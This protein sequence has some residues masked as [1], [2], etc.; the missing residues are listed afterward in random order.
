MKKGLLTV[1]FIFV[2]FSGLFSLNSENVTDYKSIEICRDST[3][4]KTI[5]KL[6]TNNIKIDSITISNVD[7]T[8]DNFI[9]LNDSVWHYIYSSYPRSKCAEVYN[10]LLLG[11]HS[12]KLHI[13]LPGIYLY[14]WNPC[15]DAPIYDSLVK[16]AVPVMIDSIQALKLNCSSWEKIKTKPNSSDPALISLL[17]EMYGDTIQ[18]VDSSHVEIYLFFEPENQ[19]YY[20]T[21]ITLD[22]VYRIFP[23]DIPGAPISY[24]NEL[25]E[26]QIRFDHQKVYAVELPF[27]IYSYFYFKNQWFTL[28]RGGDRS[29]TPIDDVEIRFKK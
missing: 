19:V 26:N 10:Q 1:S 22:S 15:K 13:L 25:E 21:I 23:Q 9:Q 14:A 3:R 20:N 12:N 7:F 11:T 27:Q 8:F 29:I 24:I 18:K 6:V 17:K 16:M 2:W 4:H 28:N 5:L